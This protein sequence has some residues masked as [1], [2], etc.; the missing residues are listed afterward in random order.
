MDSCCRFGKE[1]A[2]V[3]IKM[4]R[5]EILLLLTQRIVTSGIGGNLACELSSLLSRTSV[6]TWTRPLRERRSLGAESGKSCDS[7]MI[8]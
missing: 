2:T 7:H 8:T 3:S 1:A 4:E 6:L 5:F